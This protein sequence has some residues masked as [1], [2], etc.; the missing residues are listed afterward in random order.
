MTIQRFHTFVCV[1]A[2]VNI[3]I[4]LLCY[5]FFAFRL[6]I[7]TDMPNSQQPP[8]VYF[9]PKVYHFNLIS[10]SV[11]SFVGDA[12]HKGANG[13]PYFYSSFHFS[14]IIFFA[15]FNR[16]D[17][18]LIFIKWA[19]CHIPILSTISCTKVVA[20]S[21]RAKF[22]PKNLLFYEFNNQK[23]SLSLRINGSK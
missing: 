7:T 6:H 13:R 8:I 2:P 18:P 11:C 10:K 19:F 15:S 20:L 1:Y 4:A 3:I 17:S 9:T 22:P 14:L 16:Y 21:M 23:I 5:S 12:A